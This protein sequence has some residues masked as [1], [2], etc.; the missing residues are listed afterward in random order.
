MKTIEIT[1]AAPEQLKLTHH[2][3]EDRFRDELCEG[4][5][6]L[7]SAGAEVIHAAGPRAAVPNSYR[8]AYKIN[9]PYWEYSGGVIKPCNGKLENRPR[10]Q[11]I[12]ARYLVRAEATPAGFRCFQRNDDGTM[13]VRR[14]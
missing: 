2:T 4:I 7:Q 9:A 6:E 12:P 10:G 13:L 3:L 8:S 14:A 11:Q 1:P 5:S